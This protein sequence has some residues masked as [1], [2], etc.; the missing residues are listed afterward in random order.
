MRGL[1]VL[2]DSPA[3]EQALEILA[4]GS[5]RIAQGIRG[6]HGPSHVVFRRNRRRPPRPCVP[7]SR[8]RTGPRRR[9]R[10]NNLPEAINL[11]MALDA[12]TTTSTA[13]PASTRLAT[14]T[15]PAA[16]ASH[17]APRLPARTARPV[18]QAVRGWPSTKPFSAAAPSF[19]HLVHRIDIRLAAPGQLRND[20]R[21]A[22]RRQLAR[23]AGPARAQR[24]RR[25]APTRRRE[26]PPRPA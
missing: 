21:G 19:L 23:Q 9:D 14:S 15:P 10:A 8:F 2:H 11:S 16:S 1:T 6:K 20:G 4:G 24:T 26:F 25:P 13:S 7:P 5:G 3:R 17:G 22:G 18:P 12:S